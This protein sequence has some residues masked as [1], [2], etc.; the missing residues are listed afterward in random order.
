MDFT[1][2]LVKHVH[3]HV[4]GVN[5]VNFRDNPEPCVLTEIGDGFD[6]VSAGDNYREAVD[7]RA[8]GGDAD[9]A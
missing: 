3:R 4:I 8:D 6:D 2:R 5:K 7:A 1:E 9:T